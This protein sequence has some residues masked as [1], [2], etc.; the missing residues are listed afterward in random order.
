VTG[1]ALHVMLFLENLMR[2]LLIFNGLRSRHCQQA[3]LVYHY[4]LRSTRKRVW[5]LAWI[6]LLGDCDDPRTLPTRP[7]QAAQRGSMGGP[8]IPRHGQR[9]RRCASRVV[10]VLPPGCP[11][12]RCGA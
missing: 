4:P 12:A 9:W 8:R 6:V 10:P 7:W 11:R 2:E 3:L 5:K 1:S